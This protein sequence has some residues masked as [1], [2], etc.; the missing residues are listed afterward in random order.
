MSSPER[1]HQ[2]FSACTELQRSGK[3]IHVPDRLHLESRDLRGLS[4]AS[5]LVQSLASV[6]VP[7][8]NSASSDRLLPQQLR[9]PVEDLRLPSSLQHHEAFSGQ[10]TSVMC[11]LP[12]PLLEGSMGR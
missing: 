6:L 8:L 10:Q 3:S 11:L 2:S 5:L 4:E 7:V 12:S 1:S 9:W